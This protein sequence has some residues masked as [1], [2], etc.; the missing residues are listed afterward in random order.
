[1]ILNK[2][3][4]RNEAKAE[5]LRLGQGA[6]CALGEE[7]TVSVSENSSTKSYEVYVDGFR[8]FT[9][10]TWDSALGQLSCAIYPLV[11]VSQ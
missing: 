8:Y 10:P 1:M 9:G 2:I 4:T 11:E 6:F 7:E 5:L 3:K